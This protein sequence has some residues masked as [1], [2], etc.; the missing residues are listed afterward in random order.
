[1]YKGKIILKPTNDGMDI[2]TSV[3]NAG[4]SYYENRCILMMDSHIRVAQLS[5]DMMDKSNHH[6]QEF[7]R[8][9]MIPKEVLKSLDQKMI[10]KL[11]YLERSGLYAEAKLLNYNREHLILG[12]NKPAAIGVCGASEIRSDAG[13]IILGMTST[14]YYEML[15][16][17]NAIAQASNLA[18]FVTAIGQMKSNTQYAGNI[19]GYVMTA[20]EFVNYVLDY[21]PLA[22]LLIS[23]YG[24]ESVA[25]ELLPA[26]IDGQSP[27][28]KAAIKSLIGNIN[29]DIFADGIQ[30]RF[31]K[32]NNPLWP[33]ETL[34][35]KGAF[36]ACR[37]YLYKK[38]KDVQI[39]IN[40]IPT[41]VFHHPLIIFDSLL[42]VG[43]KWA[44]SQPNRLLEIEVW[45]ANTIHPHDGF[46]Y[47]GIEMTNNDYPPEMIIE[48]TAEIL[49]NAKVDTFEK[50]IN[51]IGMEM[52]QEIGENGEPIQ[53]EW[54][55]KQQTTLTEYMK[56]AGHENP[57]VRGMLRKF[58]DSKLN[59]LM[60]GNVKD[61][62]SFFSWVAPMWEGIFNRQWF[63]DT[64][65]HVSIVIRKNKQRQPW[66]EGDVKGDR[67][68]EMSPFSSRVYKMR[69]IQFQVKTAPLGVIV[70][71]MG[72]I[73][74]IIC[75]DGMDFDP[76]V[77]KMKK[78]ISHMDHMIA[79]RLR[80]QPLMEFQKFNPSAMVEVIDLETLPEKLLKMI[81]PV[82]Y[83]TYMQ[84]ASQYR[85]YRAKLGFDKLL[86]HFN[87]AK[88]QAVE[89]SVHMD[90]P[91]TG[92]E[93][94]MD[95]EAEI[96][97][98]HISKYGY[99]CFGIKLSDIASDVLAGINWD[100]MDVFCSKIG[101]C[102]YCLDEEAGM[103]YLEFWGSEYDRSTKQVT[104]FIPKWN[105]SRWRDKFNEVE[106]DWREM[107]QTFSRTTKFIPTLDENG[108]I[109][110]PTNGTLV[111]RGLQGNSSAM[112][113]IFNNIVKF[114]TS[115][116]IDDMNF[117]SNDG[118]SARDPK[119]Y[120]EILDTYNL[121]MKSIKSESPSWVHAICGLSTDIVRQ[122]M[123][124][125]QFVDMRGKKRVDKKKFGILMDNM[126]EEFFPTIKTLLKIDEEKAA[127]IIA[128]VMY[129]WVEGEYCGI[130]IVY[131]CKECAGVMYNA[132]TTCRHCNSNKII[133]YRPDD[134]INTADMPMEMAEKLQY[135]GE[136]KDVD[137]G[138]G[139]EYYIDT[140]MWVNGAGYVNGKLGWIAKTELKNTWVII[141]LINGANIRYAMYKV[142]RP[143][144]QFPLMMPL[145]V[146]KEFIPI[147]YAKVN[148]L[149]YTPPEQE[150]KAVFEINNTYNPIF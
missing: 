45:V 24:D 62:N 119:W 130:K 56:T 51:M 123:A 54:I 19:W 124:L 53:P 91:K 43:K 81:S 113:Y 42:K 101:G 17:K 145:Y 83:I 105:K 86:R 16:G 103:L 69:S 68:P 3:E 137:W 128:T 135:G 141:R 25:R 139:V 85:V 20:A 146:V 65:N 52:I 84:Q 36:V 73:P 2:L 90:S 15:V 6:V 111:L 144:Q 23:K 79:D 64:F 32:P 77:M 108:I 55:Q 99:V 57:G 46:H 126:L 4:H 102:N 71:G 27:I 143:R 129:R 118:V 134:F 87:F 89:G 38:H 82:G 149:Q 58:V 8:S 48:Q 44:I 37:D 116:D 33:I 147:V 97:T 9:L 121:D 5:I 7:M 10:E 93:A 138:L 49:D 30:V 150:Q 67:M 72:L 125:S 13:E 21:A 28:R 50:S 47:I 92:A 74:L 39:A 104:Y 115:R 29:G 61:P 11:N 76:D 94:T 120:Q 66:F 127:R 60:A 117:N 122:C 35:G 14:N 114:K 80:N 78:V 95:T 140:A 12:L 34:I 26:Y 88:C 96:Q 112:D 41:K 75:H 70:F 133:S 142:K 148:K 1:M 31:F 63:I 59:N 132:A 109:Q 100:D 131:V 106:I 22:K 40:N 98:D 136:V 18:K 107:G 110:K